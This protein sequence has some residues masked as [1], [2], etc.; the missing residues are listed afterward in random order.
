MKKFTCSCLVAGSGI[1]GLRAAKDLAVKGVDTI[2]ITDGVLCGGAS[3]YPLTGGLGSQM[4]DSEED[5]EVFFNEVIETGATMADPDLTRLLIEE[6]PKGAGDLPEIGL[7]PRKQYS[8]RPACFAKRERKLLSWGDWDKCREEAREIFSKEETLRIM[9]HC[10]LVRIIVRDGAVAGAVICDED[11]ELAYIET[12]AV[13]L[14]LGGF[15]GLYKHSLNTNETTGT[16]HSIALDAGASLVNM[17]FMQFI[18]GFTKPVYKLLFSETTL[19]RAC[20]VK[21][22]D[23][24]DALNEI[25]PPDVS[26]RKCL[27]DRAMHGPFTTEDKSFWFDAAIMRDAG[28]KRRE[29]G[30]EITFEKEIADDSNGFIRM[31]REMYAKY[32][33][34][35]SKDKI[36][37]APFAHCSNG[38]V[39]IDGNGFTGVPGLYA[40]GE[41]AGGVH[42]A[43]R[44]GGMA[45]SA[46]FV[47][48]RRAAKAASEYVSDKKPACVN[49]EEIVN[50]LKKWLSDGVSESEL[51]PE[52]VMER[53]GTLLWY[54]GNCIRTGENLKAA[55]SEI[56]GMK[57]GFQVNIE[58]DDLKKELRA[59]HAIRTA[60][61]LIEAMLMRKESRGPHFREDYP[62]RNRE[63]DYK[64]VYI[65]EDDGSLKLDLR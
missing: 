9:E 39:K 46:A 51:S 34:D 14:C 45:T 42:G 6:T 17:E 38:G 48:G 33:I 61:A 54:E 2:L 41:Q 64:R 15:C 49:E 31:A 28:E 18:P 53:I 3:F 27:D 58:S 23:G 10:D 7:H 11:D 4:Y 40:A 57:E 21:D 62:V 26:F 32:G 19:R 12:P 8:D 37:L 44:H 24:N 30:F 59:F 47:F 13:I 35:L 20:S 22:A 56:K 25:L 63:Y 60:E 16:G 50:D 29:C 43:D 52:Y 5:K 55:L 65:S 1:A 36:W